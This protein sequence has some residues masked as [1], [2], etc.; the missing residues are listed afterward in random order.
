MTK[1][2][3][4]SLFLSM[5]LLSGCGKAGK[6]E[7]VQVVQNH[8]ELSAETN[9]AVI[10]SIEDEIAEMTASGTLTEDSRT[11]IEDLITRLQL[12]TTQ[13]KLIEE[14][15]NANTVN[16]DLLSQLLRARWEKGNDN[17]TL[18]KEIVD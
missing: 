16:K 6:L 14:Y 11:A 12:V 9:A 17:E 1:K 8:S 2:L 5:V 15:V 3:I 10:S 4:M 18:N 13:A 7:F